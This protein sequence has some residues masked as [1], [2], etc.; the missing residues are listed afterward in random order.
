MDYYKK[1]LKYKYKYINLKKQYGTGS[2][3]CN[4][5]YTNGM[6]FNETVRK[7]N[8]ELYIVDKIFDKIDKKDIYCCNCNSY[9]HRI[10]INSCLKCG[11][12]EKYHKQTFDKNTT[13]YNNY[14][15]CNNII[16]K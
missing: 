10:K 2:G 3:K 11:H 14:K 6:P 12:E 7:A 16:I 8:G 9:V 1:Y 13:E 4:F 5:R 15:K